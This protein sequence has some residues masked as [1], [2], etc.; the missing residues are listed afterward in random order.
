MQGVYMLG[1]FLL[2][3]TFLSLDKVIFVAM[4]HFD[5]NLTNRD[6]IYRTCIS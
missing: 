1:G 3:E 2:A 5:C 6:T 4:L